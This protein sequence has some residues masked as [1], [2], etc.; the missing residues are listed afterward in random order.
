[1][2]RLKKEHTE[3]LKKMERE[4]ILEN[5]LK[6]PYPQW[7][8]EEFDVLCKK[9]NELVREGN[10]SQLPRVKELMKRFGS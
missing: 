7:S 9:N 2:E 10:Q 4:K 1:M 5:L 8:K 3:L 6:A